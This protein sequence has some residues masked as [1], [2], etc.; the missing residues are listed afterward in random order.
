MGKG[1]YK[2]RRHADIFNAAENLTAVLAA[3]EAE[4]RQRNNPHPSTSLQ[5]FC[6]STN[7]LF[8]SDT[9]A[10][11]LESDAGD[12]IFDEA[13]RILSERYKQSKGILTADDYLGWPITLNIPSLAQIQKVQNNYTA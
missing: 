3:S 1:L 4:L 11:L 6:N 13:L 9:I 5:Q 2:T 10:A 8:I 7:A 12:D